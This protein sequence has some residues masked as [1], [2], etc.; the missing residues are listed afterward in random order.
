MFKCYV[1]CVIISIAYGNFEND[2]SLATTSITSVSS[3]S[4]AT[5]NNASEGS[6]T[7]TVTTTLF[8]GTTNET[9]ITSSS[10]GP[11]DTNSPTSS[12]VES[13]SS[14][15]STSGQTAAIA[16]LSVCLALVMIGIVGFQVRKRYKARR[17]AVGD[18]SMASLSRNQN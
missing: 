3:D 16:V 2:T 11:V 12:T 8:N 1:L 17:S 18:V 14:S 7:I 9:D 6:S 13:T 10:P 15:P 4:N 5:L